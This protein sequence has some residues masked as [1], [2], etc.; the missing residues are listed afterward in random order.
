MYAPRRLTRNRSNRGGGRGARLLQT[1]VPP[2]NP[3][4][5]RW[6]GSA[7]VRYPETSRR[8]NVEVEGA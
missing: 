4:A 7:R 5:M 1:D 8:V 2:Y 3:A 6:F